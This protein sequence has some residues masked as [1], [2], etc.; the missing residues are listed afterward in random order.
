MLSMTAAMEA[1]NVAGLALPATVLNVMVAFET[2]TV[3]GKRTYDV[4][5]PFA[6]TRP[7]RSGTFYGQVMVGPTDAMMES[8][9][10][11][12]NLPA[13]S[14]RNWSYTWLPSSVE[15]GV[16]SMHHPRHIEQVGIV[17][18]GCGKTGVQG[19]WVWRKN[20]EDSKMRFCKGCKSA[21][22]NTGKAEFKLPDQCKIE[23][24]A[25]VRNGTQLRYPTYGGVFRYGESPVDPSDYHPMDELEHAVAE[26]LGTQKDLVYVPMATLREIF[27]DG[28][29]NV[30][31][32]IPGLVTIVGVC[33]PIE[34]GW[35]TE[36]KLTTVQEFGFPGVA[37]ELLNP[38]KAAQRPP[39]VY[40]SITV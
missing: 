35:V 28:K 8:D 11:M 25:A 14:L 27:G 33:R 3:L 12:V 40:G 7:G 29:G 2:P 13:E 38:S 24:A 17:C 19:A 15:D 20:A 18:T 21:L 23:A 36:E 26:D 39:N 31:V 32:G 30:G 9:A 1:A 22:R 34:A 37:Q 10:N 6:K 4:R 16:P 5:K